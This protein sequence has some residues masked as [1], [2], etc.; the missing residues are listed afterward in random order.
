MLR[1]FKLTKVLQK[2]QNFLFPQKFSSLN[3]VDFQ[4]FLP[5]IKQTKS[6]EKIELKLLHEGENGKRFIFEMENSQT[7]G[8]F[9]KKLKE[10]MDF[11][12]LKA[13]SLDKVELASSIT[14]GD[15]KSSNFYIIGNEKYLFK[16]IDSTFEN[17]KMSQGIEKY[18]DE[19]DISYLQKKIIVS[20]LNRFDSLNE[21]KFGTKLFSEE[22]SNKTQSVDKEALIQN[23]VEAL[24]SNR[25]KLIHDEEV[26]LSKYLN[27]K[28]EVE[29]LSREK[30]DLENTVFF[31]FIP[32][33]LNFR[34]I[35]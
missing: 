21:L 19:F 25:P 22:G 9:L 10:N 24:P 28:R 1:F 6:N 3:T 34:L 20:Y 26:F 27:L 18:C 7:I 30:K 8:D 23:L 31:E 4:Q 29:A 33:N 11:K 16:I 13:Y 14:L 35:H 5:I 32:I 12:S 2:N 15:M 17:F